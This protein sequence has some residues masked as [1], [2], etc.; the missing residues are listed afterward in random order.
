M[1]EERNMESKRQKITVEDMLRCDE[2]FVIINNAI[3]E[4]EE[5]DKDFG[6]RFDDLPF[7]LKSII[8]DNYWKE[9]I[10]VNGWNKM[11]TMQ[12]GGGDAMIHYIKEG[13]FDKIIVQT[14]AL[15]VFYTRMEHEELLPIRN[16]E[17]K[18]FDK[19]MLQINE[20]FPRIYVFTL[21]TNNRYNWK[22]FNSFEFEYIDECKGY[23]L[24]ID[25]TN[26]YIRDM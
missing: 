4:Q 8:K 7:E 11:L 3:E 6:K 16:T 12:D 18:L 14:G 22:I 15:E 2:D 13:F 20:Q 10:H 19:M 25:D 26:L 24:F 5:A 9:F 1:T 21:Y 23:C 17:E